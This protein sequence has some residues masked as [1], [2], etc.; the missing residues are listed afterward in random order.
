MKLKKR[1]IIATMLILVITA[2]VITVQAPSIYQPNESVVKRD[3]SQT[4][5][6]EALQTL[7]VKGRSPKTGYSRDQFGSGWQASAGCDTRNLILNRDLSDVVTN[8]RC[9]VISGTLS[10]PYT[11][12]TLQF[13]RGASTS[14]E[15]QIDHVVA[16]ADAWQK[17]AQLLS[18]NERETFAND[19]LELLAVDGEA[20]QQKS[21]SDA[22]SWLPGNKGFRCE[23]VARQIAVK[24]KYQL[25][26]TQAEHDAMSRV[27]STCPS[28]PLP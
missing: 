28:Q 12:K 22:A 19:P 21:G 16:L 15:V 1:R 24:I 10:D 11:G 14:G 25:W 13:N 8:D 26:V 2:L 17:G 7:P 4:L 20:N 27:L 6:T 5:A 3:S 18:K 23:Y 9:E